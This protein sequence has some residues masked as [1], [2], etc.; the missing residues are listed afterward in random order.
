MFRLWQGVG[1]LFGKSNAN[2]DD[3]S[4]LSPEEILSK[5]K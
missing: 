3:M 4:G 1:I 5:R 2:V